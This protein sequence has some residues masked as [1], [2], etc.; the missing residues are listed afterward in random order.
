MIVHSG[1]SA[2]CVNRFDHRRLWR[3]ERPAGA[4]Q[5]RH[6]GPLDFSVL[7][8]ILL[9]RSELFVTP[10]SKS[11]GLYDGSVFQF[12]CSFVCLSPVKFITSLSFA[13]WQHMAADE[14]LLYRLR[15]CCAASTF[16]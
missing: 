12:V 4:S 8:F 2:L 6:G 15:L 16:W 14:D 5:R 1:D 9:P 10:I 7:C 13:T 3:T 11:G